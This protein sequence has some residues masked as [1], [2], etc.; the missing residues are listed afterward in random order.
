[1]R[2]SLLDSSGVGDCLWSEQDE[3]VGRVTRVAEPCHVWCDSADLSQKAGPVDL[4]EGVLEVVGVASQ[5]PTE[6][7]NDGLTN[8][9]GSQLQ[10][11][12]MLVVCHVLVH[13]V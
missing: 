2:V 12:G 8:A 9:R 11:C 6:G 10:L 3:G 5:P 13:C 4:I 1:M 7:E